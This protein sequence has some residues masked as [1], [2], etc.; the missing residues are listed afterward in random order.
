M[1]GDGPSMECR[2]LRRLDLDQVRK[3]RWRL[4]HTLRVLQ[5]GRTGSVHLCTMQPIQAIQV[6]DAN[7]AL[8]D[9]EQLAALE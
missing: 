6:A 4:I 3:R 5:T 8:L 7:M 2:N 9:V 1:V